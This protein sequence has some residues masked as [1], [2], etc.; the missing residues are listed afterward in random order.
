VQLGRSYTPFADVL[1]RSDA[2]GYAN[3]A[4]LSNTIYQNL[5]GITGAQYTW[6]NNAVKYLSPTFG[7]LSA[8][9]MQSLGG[10]AGDFAAGRMRSAAIFYNYGRFALNGA[11][12]DANDPGG[13]SDD[14]LVARSFT[15]AAVYNGDHFKIGLDA[16][17]FKN[18]VLD[19][20]QT[21][22]SV[23][24][25]YHLSPTNDI[26]ADYTFLADKVADRDGSYIKLGIHHYLSKLTDL[27]AEGGIA[28]N[29]SKGEVGIASV[30]PSSPGINQTGLMVGVRHFF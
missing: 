10:V 13:T 2:S 16:A 27:Y 6:S 14:K 3:F 23:G 25:T 4:S 1:Y 17:N 29:H 7:G 26:V 19:T 30:F 15:V 11:Y 21:F 9:L 28:R 20:N 8:E 24:G 18:P 12:L 22:Y 5:T